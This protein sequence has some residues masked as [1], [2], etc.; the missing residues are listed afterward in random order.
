MIKTRRFYLGAALLVPLFFFS[1]TPQEQLEPEDE[2]ISPETGDPGSSEG[3]AKMEFVG[4]QADDDGSRTYIS[5]S[6]VLWKGSDKIAVIDDA[7]PYVHVF[8]NTDTEG[9]ER[10]RFIG[11]AKAGEDTWTVVYPADA[12]TYPETG[13][14]DLVIPATQRAVEG[15]FADGTYFTFCRT[16]S[17]NLTMIPLLSM[18]KIHIAYENLKQVRIMANSSPSFDGTVRALSGR[19]RFNYAL[20]PENVDYG[21]LNYKS[22]A[23]YITLRPPV[24]CETFPAADYYIPVAPLGD[25]DATYRGEARDVVANLRLEFTRADNQVASRSLTGATIVF[26]RGKYFDLGTV[27]EGLSWEYFDIAFGEVT[28]IMAKTQ[29]YRWPFV[30]WTD[31]NWTT[32]KTVAEPITEGITLGTQKVLQF[33]LKDSGHIVKAYNNALDENVRVAGGAKA[34]FIGSK[35]GDYIEFPAIQNRALLRV[36]VQYDS[37]STHTATSGEGGSG[38]VVGFSYCKSRTANQCPHITTTSDVDVAYTMS[39]DKEGFHHNYNLF[40]TEIGTAYRYRLEFNGGN[41]AGPRI[42]RIRLYYSK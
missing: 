17:K 5:G 22:D 41:W 21:R 42:Q 33:K 36:E 20:S 1:C 23:S 40:N 13:K 4:T 35:T 30:S 39:R 28:D 19:Y 6:K 7:A 8:D 29:E 37:L 11:E 38:E 15:S 27:D 34:L 25:T 9:G 24:G 31:D 16:S 26:K 12:F 2:V 32:T 10:C 18:L 14:A 3:L